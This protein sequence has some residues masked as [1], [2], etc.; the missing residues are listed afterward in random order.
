MKEM[1]VLQLCP[2]A[3]SLSLWQADTYLAAVVIIL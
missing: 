3:D 2:R 1:M